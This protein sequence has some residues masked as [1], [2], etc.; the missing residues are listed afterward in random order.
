MTALEHLISIMEFLQNHDQHSPWGN[1]QDLNAIVP[2]TIENAYVLADAIQHKDEIKIR[3]GLGELI[4][5]VIYLLHIA[6]NKGLLSFSGVIED[7]YRKLTE[8]SSRQV[9]GMESDTGGCRSHTREKSGSREDRNRPGFSR[10]RSG[11]L[12]EIPVDLPALSRAQRLQQQAARVGFDW[13]DIG[14]VWDKL[15]EELQE[16]KSALSQQASHSEIMDEAGDLI[17]VCVNLCRH[18]SVDAESALGQAN[19]KFRTRFNFIED[20]TNQDGRS[21]EELSLDEMDK[22]WEQAKSNRVKG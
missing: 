10:E 5:Q 8:Q 20:R 3:S 18:L 13:K 9:A 4:L 17:F 7:I 2:H 19:N 21:L 1:E 15:D 14:P 11:L 6:E 16:I 12:D 22:L